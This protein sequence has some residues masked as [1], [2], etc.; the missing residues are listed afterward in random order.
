VVSDRDFVTTVGL[1][2]VRLII[3]NTHAEYWTHESLARIK[4]ACASGISVAILS[5]NTGYRVVQ[6]LGGS[7]RVMSQIAPRQFVAETLGAF[8]DTS[9][10]RTG[11]GYR[12]VR[13][14]HWLWQGLCLRNGDAFGLPSSGDYGAS[15]YETDTLA[16]EGNGFVTLAI[17]TNVEGPA[18]LV[19]KDEPS[20]SFFLNVGSV[21]F[22]S[23]I[24]RDR[25]VDGIIGNVLDRARF[26]CT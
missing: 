11:G 25:V 22:T 19:V 3:F 12:V 14:D 23:Q 17:G 21:S 20:G 2:G 4:E 9:G 24:G 7:I 18:Y 15:G 6:H 10:Y 13:S 5:G 1:E 16:P 26:R 8:Y